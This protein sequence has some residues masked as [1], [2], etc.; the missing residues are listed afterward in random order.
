[1]TRN[2]AKPAGDSTPQDRVALR[3]LHQTLAKITADFDNR[4]HFNTSIAA[5]MELMNTLEEQEAGLSAVAAAAIVE[6]L[7]LMLHPFAPFLSQEIWSVELGRPG[8]VI[9]QKWPEADPGLARE[10]GAEIPVQVNGKLRSRI[11]VPFGTGRE[12]LERRALA[13]ERVAPHVAGK[14][15]AKIVILPD[16][17]INIVV[18]G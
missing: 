3:K 13:D 8:H 7:C 2:A 1:V 12:E 16:K 6:T 5:L 11:V 17:L 4:W 9:R 15:V 14:Q 10:E 18:K